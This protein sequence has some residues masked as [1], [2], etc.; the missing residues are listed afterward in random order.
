MPMTVV[1]TR[2]VAD[3]F[4]GFLASCM[5]EIAPGV[6]TSPAMNP[7]VRERVW[8]VLEGWHA[9]IGRGSV[10]MLWAD[11]RLPGG[12]GVGVLGDPPKELVEVDDHVLTRRPVPPPPPPGQQQPPGG[13]RVA[14]SLTTE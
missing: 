4:R 14:R 9:A 13:G 2:D 8:K 5:L 11:S 1:V 7:A 3:R 12:Q 10:V 6:Y